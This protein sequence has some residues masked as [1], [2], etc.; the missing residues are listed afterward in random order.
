MTRTPFS[1]EERLSTLSSEQARL[2]EV[3]VARESRH[4]Q[5][6]KPFPR[7]EGLTA[8]P[9]SYAQQRLWFID[10][11]EGGGAAYNSGIVL[12]LR[13]QLDTEAL[14]RALVRLCHRHEILRTVFAN[15]EGDAKQIV[16]VDDS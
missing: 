8:P 9:T 4:A 6:I 3:L 11:L 13:G 1:A 2:L 15:V 10:Q 14:H 7:G 12:R 16:R 5:A